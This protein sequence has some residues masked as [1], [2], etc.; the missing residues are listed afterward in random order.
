MLRNKSI[1]IPISG[2]LLALLVIFTSI[3]IYKMNVFTPVF[4]EAESPDMNIPLDQ[5]GIY[6]QNLQIETTIYDSPIILIYIL[7]DS[8]EPMIF[9]RIND[10]ILSN[11]GVDIDLTEKTLF[12]GGVLK[13]NQRILLSATTVYPGTIDYIEITLTYSIYDNIGNGSISAELT[14][15]FNVDY[16]EIYEVTIPIK[17]K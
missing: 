12:N 8:K 17:I 3:Q 4:Q 11:N 10:I 2:A 5:N 13:S 9:V 7:I 6:K 14:E 15:S 16:N 1:L